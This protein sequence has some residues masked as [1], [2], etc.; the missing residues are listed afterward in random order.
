MPSTTNFL[1]TSGQPLSESQP[2]V[3]DTDYG[4]SDIVLS[5]AGN[6]FFERLL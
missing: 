4:R 6:P 5:T 1:Y 3:T 2:L